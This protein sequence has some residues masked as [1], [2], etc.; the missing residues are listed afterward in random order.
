MKKEM[1]GID[2]LKFFLLGFLLCKVEQPLKGI[3]LPENEEDKREK[4]TRKI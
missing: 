1:V 4:Y 3:K 2:I